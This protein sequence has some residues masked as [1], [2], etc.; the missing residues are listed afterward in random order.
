MSQHILVVGTHNRK[1]REELLELLELPRLRLVTLADLQV[2]HEVEEDSDTFIGNA[3]KKAVELAL[4]LGQWVLG[5]DSGLVVDVLGG[6]PGVYSA[7]Y[8]GLPRDD[9]R[10]NDKLLFELADVPDE[11]RHAHYICTAVIADPTGRVRAQAVGR[12]HGVI[13]RARRG[14]QGFGYDPLFLIPAVNQTF[15]ELP[16]SYKQQHSHRAH[17]VQQLRPLLMELFPA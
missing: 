4:H 3:T 13:T 17:C 5:E 10:N 15:G 1:K 9:E 12:C 8:A 16:H 11:Q 6:A 7:R 2:T 14:D